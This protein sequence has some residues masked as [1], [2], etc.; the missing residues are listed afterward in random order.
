MSMTVQRRKDTR[1]P[2]VFQHKVADIRGGVSVKI[3]ELGGDYLREGAVLSAPDNGICHVVKIAEV[4]AEVGASE[5]AIKVKKLHNFK[6]GDFVM[7]AEGGLAY[8][9]TAI[10]DSGKDYD[11]ITVGT[12][13]KAIAKG[14]FLIEAAAESASN[15]SKLKY[16]PLSLV[17]TG[18]PVVSGQNLDT[19]AWLIGV[20]KGNPLP[21]C[22]AKY[23]TGIINY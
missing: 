5:T 23:L 7:T 1:V 16:T 2:R 4:V 22:V 21:E 9:I 19:D 14:G 20:T 13:L 8:A 17:G 12:T 11:T 15:T 6:V 18:K 3:S 10:D